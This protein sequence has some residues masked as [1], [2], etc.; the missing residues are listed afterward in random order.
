MFLRQ[1]RPAHF[2]VVMDSTT[3]TFRDE[4]YA[5]YKANREDTPE[6]LRLQMPIIEEILG[7]MGVPMLRVEGYEADDV[8]ATLATRC[9]EQG[10]Q[11]YMITGDKDLLQLVDGSVRVLKPDQNRF[12]E[13]GRDEVHEQW[14]VYPEQILDFLALLGDNVDNVP[15]VKGIGKKTAARLL[16]DYGTLDGIYENLEHLS[17]KS[18]R[19]RLEEGRDS[20]YFSRRM[21]LLATSAPLEE[22]L[23]DLK[24]PELDI[25]AA[26]PYFRREGMNSLISEAQRGPEAAGESQQREDAEGL[27]DAQQ[28]PGKYELVTTVEG[29]RRWVERLRNA[30]QFAF[31]SETD[32]LDPMQARPVGFS[33][34]DGAGTGCY[35]PLVGPD[36]PVLPEESARDLLAELFGDES[37]TVIGQNLKYDYKILRRW[38]IEVHNFAFDTMIAAW[39][40]DSAEG[41]Y[42]LDALAKR[43]LQYKPISYRDVIPEAKR[44]ERELRFDEVPLDRAVTYATEDADLAYRLYE[45]FAPMLDSAGHSELFYQVEMPL[46]TLLGEMELAGIKLSTERLEEYSGELEGQLAALE[47]EVYKLCGREFNLASTKQL[48][49]VL[50]EERKLK[51]IRKTKTGYSTDTSVLQELAREDPVPEKVLRHRLLS[52]LKSTYVDALPKLVDPNTGRLHTHFNQTG[53]ATGRLSST[54]PN[55]QNIPIRDE[56]GRRIREAFIPEEGHRFVS[57]DYSQIE[58]VILA[59]LSGDP[60]LGEAFRTGEDVHRKTGALIFGV[61][62]AEVSNEQRR[63][64]KTINFGVMYGMSAFRLSRELGI[65]RQDAQTF[66]ERYFSTYASIKSFVD[67]TVSEAERT[68]KVSTL[69]GRE[70]ALPDINNRNR[71]VKSA[72]ERIAVNTPIQGSAADIVKLA[73]LAVSRRLRREKLRSALLVQVHDELI[74]EVPEE[75]VETVREL[76]YEEMSGAVELSVPLRVSVESGTSWGA[77]H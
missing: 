36:G 5:E 48:Q 54:E 38:G 17:K 67:R 52:K 70:R 42:G 75:E 14:G 57:A 30:G 61:E 62:P 47:Q 74:L 50:F 40:L 2:A 43:Y 34:S 51:P 56:E 55:L 49:Q 20:A 33:F 19:E 4:Q 32:A 23:E 65:P 72:S 59:H 76:L 31:D 8:M 73:M 25:E 69:L 46:V 27:D 6:D 16:Q 39:L 21:I 66:I 71:T 60:A 7:A 24:L 28:S 26:I 64:A 3:A 13:I 45:H 11:C 41:S 63:I 9:S 35:V 12:E 22:S 18:W 44:G 77:L 53:T 10:W 29:F 68:G 1:Y 37:L 15:G 58:L